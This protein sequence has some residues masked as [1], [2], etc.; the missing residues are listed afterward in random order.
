M[1]LN[2]VSN[3]DILVSCHKNIR[4]GTIQG[5]GWTKLEDQQNSFEPYNRRSWR[6]RPFGTPPCRV[7][8]PNL[9]VQVLKTT[10][11]ILD[12]AMV[13]TFERFQG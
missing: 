11:Q 3:L 10:Q 7:D 5:F 1:R 8:S 13:Y 2:V 4:M 6:H 9:D 12:S